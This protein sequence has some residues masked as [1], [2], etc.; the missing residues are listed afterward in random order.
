MRVRRTKSRTTV[1][2][3]ALKNRRKN[4]LLMLKS[5]LEMER[6]LLH[7]GFKGTGIA[8]AASFLTF[9]HLKS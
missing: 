1:E 8:N 7:F 4:N 2:E 3:L 5:R 9:S 6:K